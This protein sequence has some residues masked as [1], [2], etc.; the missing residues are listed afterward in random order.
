MAADKTF[1]VLAPR[2][3]SG[4]AA[5]D[6]TLFLKE[7]FS[8]LAFVLPA[9]YALWHRHWIMAVLLLVADGLLGAAFAALPVNEGAASAI[10]LVL[11]LLCGAEAVNL[12]RALLTRKRF[13]ERAVVH[14]PTREEAER[15]YFTS[16][17]GIASFPVAAGP[18]SEVP[19]RAS[20]SGP[21]VL[22][23]FPHAD[24]RP[25]GLG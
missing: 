16:G 11:H 18:V 17:D 14:A 15:R 5:E 9:A 22:G 19:F 20:S 1:I 8:L 23:L 2:G 25:R 7:G 4:A 13:D 6:K 21:Q 12:R 3:L 24:T 10:T